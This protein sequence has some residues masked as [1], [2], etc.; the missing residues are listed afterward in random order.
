MDRVGWLNRLAALGAKHRQIV[1]V[2]VIQ[3]KGSAP[4]DAGTKMFV[5]DGGFDGTIGGGNLEFQALEQA[6]RLLTLDNE[7]HRVQ[8]F[9]LGPLLG[10]CC[11]GH[12]TLWLERLRPDDIASLLD[13][14]QGQWCQT[15][16]LD[17]RKTLLD[18]DNEQTSLQDRVRAPLHLIETDGT[19]RTLLEPLEEPLP[20]IYIFG[21]GHVGQALTTALAPLPVTVHWVDSRQDLFPKQ[22]PANMIAHTTSDFQKIIKNAPGGAIFVVMTHDHGLDF[23]IVAA[24]FDRGD[25][26]Y[27]GLI[28]SK[29]KRARFERRLTEERSIPQGDLKR[30]I[31]PIGLPSIGGK[32]P[33]VIAASVTAELLTVMSVAHSNI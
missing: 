30:L 6:R 18:A 21:A 10:Q 9:P 13:A 27:L 20:P 2:T 8:R 19:V 31:C 28:G 23:D 1:A 12:V 33:A 26:E 17:G 14:G 5:Y 15:N 29:T 16:L 11:G 25:F 7:T 22:L 32:E 3:A 24:L 4:R